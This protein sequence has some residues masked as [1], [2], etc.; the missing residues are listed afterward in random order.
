MT[1]FRSALPNHFSLPK[2]IARLAELS[3]NL[4][5]TWNFDAQRLFLR[6]D[7]I[8]WEETYHNPVKF[9]RKVERAK[10]NAVTNN[11]YYLEFYDRLQ[12]QP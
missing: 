11:R 5:W 1:I 7:P 4:W 12:H 3:Y 10:L 9:L 2:R 8:L 6:I